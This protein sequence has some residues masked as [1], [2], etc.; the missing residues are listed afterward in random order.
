[1]TRWLGLRSLLFTPGDDPRKL[2]KARASRADALIF[3]LEDAVA[4]ERKAIARD[5]TS[6]QIQRGS[7]GGHLVFVRANSVQSGRALEDL[8][9]VVGAGLDGVWLPKAEAPEHV[10]AV[11][12][13]APELARNADRIE[14]LQVDAAH[15]RHLHIGDQAGDAAT[16]SRGQ[17]GLGRD[18][19]HDG[20]AE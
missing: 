4:D 6:E 17:E 20:E 7:D 18:K 2:A 3:D 15:A 13:G 11:A 1:M 5:L 16:D 9:A 10:V 19:C 14:A 12:E 8:E